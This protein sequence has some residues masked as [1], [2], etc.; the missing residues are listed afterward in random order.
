MLLLGSSESDKHLVWKTLK[1]R[2]LAELTDEERMACKKTIRFNT[3]QGMRNLVLACDDLGIMFEDRNDSTADLF[4]FKHFVEQNASNN[5]SSA[6][7]KVKR[8]WSDSGIQQAYDRCPEFELN[9]LRYFFDNIDRIGLDDFVVEDT[10]YLNTNETTGVLQLDFGISNRTYR[11]VDGSRQL[12]ARHKWVHH[13]QNC[14]AI[15]FCAALDEYDVSLP[16]DPCV[17]RMW[18]SL[19]LFDEIANITWFDKTSIILLLTKKDAFEEKVAR[20][21]VSHLQQCF[22][23]FTGQ[24]IEDAHN[25][26]RD[27]FL[28]KS[29]TGS[30]IY[31]NIVNASNPNVVNFVDNSVGNTLLNKSFDDAGY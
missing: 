1:T 29:R 14:T 20:R 21:G 16:E 3:L 8:L 27:K 13:F 5:F 15:I 25:F 18:E 22:P 30:N 6:A 9:H 17:N 12:G 26:I 24:S 28:S 19:K 23:E 11:V 2:Q 31:A 10:D 7:Q 4:K